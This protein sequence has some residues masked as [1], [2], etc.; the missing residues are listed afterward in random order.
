VLKAVGW[1]AQ[2]RL[3]LMVS[4]MTLKALEALV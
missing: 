2:A 4:M 3:V 1:A